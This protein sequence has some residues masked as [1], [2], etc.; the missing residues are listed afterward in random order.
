MWQKYPF[1]YHGPF[2]FVLSYVVLELINRS[3]VIAYADFDMNL[4]VFFYGLVMALFF[5]L[6][7]GVFPAYKMSRLQAVDALK[8]GTL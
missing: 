3:Q 4:T 8:G 1:K 5:G 6:I 2:G 7:S